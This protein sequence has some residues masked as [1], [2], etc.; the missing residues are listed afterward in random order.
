MSTVED[1]FYLYER[2]SKF[3]HEP[4]H[5]PEDYKNCLNKTCYC[6]INK[7]VLPFTIGDQDTECNIK[8]KCYIKLGEKCPIC[9]ESIM[10]KSSAFLTVCGHAYHKKCLFKYLEY[11][12]LSTSFITSVKCPMCRCSVGYPEFMR[13]Y[14]SSYFS[15]NHKDDNQLDKLEDFWICNEY[16]L[17]ESCSNGYDHYLG[18]DSNCFICN[19]YIK[20]GFKL[21]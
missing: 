5:S 13:R 1:V 20:K 4:S 16:N 17:P 15:I 19:N 10:M 6:N 7:T 18:F 11:K 14:R 3:Y 21:Y 12:W 9:Y 2:N 8:Y